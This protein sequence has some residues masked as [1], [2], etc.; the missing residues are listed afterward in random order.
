MFLQAHFRTLFFI[1]LT[2]L[3]VSCSTTKSRRVT[4]NN[5][6]IDTS[7]FVTS[8]SEEVAL[9]K[10]VLSQNPNSLLAKSTG[11]L[12]LVYSQKLYRWWIDYFT[13]RAPKTFKDHMGN[14]YEVKKTVQKI[15]ADNGV[16][17]EVFYL[18]LI[19]SG[20]NTKIKSR[21][22]AT[23]PW[24]FMKGTAVHY[25]LRVD[26]HVD[27]R[28]NIYKA[29]EAAAHYLVDLYN[30]FGSWELALCGYNAGEYRII[31][32]IRKGNSRDYRELVA[33][34]LLPK[35]T[36]YYIPKIVAARDIFLHPERFGMKYEKRHG[37]IY[38]GVLAQDFDRSVGLKTLSR[39][40]DIPRS[41][42]ITLN[43]DLKREVAP[44]KPGQK[45]RLYFPEQYK[46]LN[47]QNWN[48]IAEDRRSL[49]MKAERTQVKRLP[50]SVVVKSKQRYK[51]YVAT[52]KEKVQEVAR[53]HGL[54][55]IKLARFNGLN[56]NKDHQLKPGQR[57]RI[58]I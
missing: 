15:L 8:T 26:E 44:L 6:A 51:I 29:T 48:L 49:G 45:I 42:L 1:I 30:I 40:F 12:D 39:Q 4:Q 56:S 7:D 46:N 20:Y 33:M 9:N 32:A 11:R 54:S 52:K 16:P 2:L 43:P 34:G 24:Q 22:Q 35:E 5:P 41:T 58:P 27:E 28:Y 36:T 18:G 53:R 23:G 31:D 47:S 55:F 13:K 19:E 3:L 38:E 17:I 14:A 37:K 50:A 25:G 10:S 21:A 57:L